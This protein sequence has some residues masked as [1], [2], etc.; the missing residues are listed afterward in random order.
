MRTLFRPALLA[1]CFA[2]LALSGCGRDSENKS[3]QSATFRWSAFPVALQMESTLAA[4]PN[5]QADL[6]D[7]IAFWEN[8]A[9]KPLFQLNA[10]YP[11]GQAAFT[12]N[13]ADPDQILANVI[14]EQSPWPFASNVAGQSIVHA[15]QN[16]T[17]HALMMINPSTVFCTGD[18][19]TSPG[20]TS[21][22]KLFAHELGH[23]LGF[24][25]STDPNDIMFP[26]IQSGGSLTNVTA[27]TGT[28]SQ[29]VD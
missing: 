2:F 29:L 14:L 5:A 28:L 27:D 26:E 9:G 3:S 10:A 21:R 23:F 13:A 22:R 24:S 4:N 17:Q 1:L 11:S 8:K 18:C 6:R 25:H 12:G 16:I 15:E 7:A 19:S 20:D